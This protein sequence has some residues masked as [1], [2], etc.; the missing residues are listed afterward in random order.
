MQ[1]KISPDQFRAIYWELTEDNSVADNAVSKEYDERLKLI[2]TVCDESI[3]LH[4]PILAYYI[5]R[6]QQVI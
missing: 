4:I 2:L 1:D 5:L 6:I 3:F